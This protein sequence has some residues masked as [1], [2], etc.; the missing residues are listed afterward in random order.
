MYIA[1]NQPVATILTG[2]LAIV[3]VVLS[4]IWLDHRQRQEH[5]H[6]ISLKNKE[7]KLK[8]KEELI[9]LANA[10]VKTISSIE[11][12]FESWLDDF[13]KNFSS[14]AIRDLQTDIDSNVAKIH[15]IVKLYFPEHLT[16]ID[17]IYEKTQDFIEFCADYSMA[18]KFGKED[19]LA[20]DPM[21]IFEKCNGYAVVFMHF[22]TRITD[23]K[24]T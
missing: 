15:L 4:Q 14:Y 2:F 20:L 6:E 8:K 1:S 9:D 23:S 3:S 17:T 11:N 7:L 12:V 16:Y 22:S 18:G 5:M 13:S 21:E 10:Q 19:F 24:S